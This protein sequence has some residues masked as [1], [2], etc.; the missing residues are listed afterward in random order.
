MIKQTIVLFSL[1]EYIGVSG[2]KKIVFTRMLLLVL[3]IKL[4][5]PIGRTY[6][7]LSKRLNF[8]FCEGSYLKDQRTQTQSNPIQL[9]IMLSLY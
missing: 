3:L 2:D 4:S 8:Y 9:P 5:H 1:Q 6:L 7:C